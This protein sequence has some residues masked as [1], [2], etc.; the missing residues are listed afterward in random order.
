MFAD[1][2]TSGSQR[3]L[4]ANYPVVFYLGGFDDARCK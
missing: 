1:H 4:S 3:L 2:K